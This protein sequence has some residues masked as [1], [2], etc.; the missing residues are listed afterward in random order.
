M[1]TDEI[2]DQYCAAWNETEIEVRRNSLASIC[3]KNGQYID[4]RSD[5]TGLEALVQHIEKI[6]AGRPGATIKRTSSVDVH[7]HLGR[8]NWHLQDQTG[9]VLLEGLDIVIF[10]SDLS[11]IEKIIGFFGPLNAA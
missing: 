7:H 1:T 11:A 8:F 3:T 4:P 9:N 6:Q 2:V 10:S 5:L